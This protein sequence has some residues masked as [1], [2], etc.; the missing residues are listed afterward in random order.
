VSLTITRGRGEKGTW[1]LVA[2]QVGGGYITDRR[3]LWG[4]LDLPHGSRESLDPEY[5]IWKALNIGFPGVT[6]EVPES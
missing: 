6:E 3:L 4:T 2:R 5:A 1:S